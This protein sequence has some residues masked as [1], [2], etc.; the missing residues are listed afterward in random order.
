MSKMQK[1][2]VLIT[3]LFLAS[4]GWLFAFTHFYGRLNDWQKSQNI[5]FAAQTGATKLSVYINSLTAA[6]IVFIVSTLL[7]LLYIKYS[8]KEK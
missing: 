2:T 5:D 1:L 7:G 6:G 3:G 4:I 8:K